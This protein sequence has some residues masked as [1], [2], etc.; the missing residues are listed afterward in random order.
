MWGISFFLVPVD[1][2]LSGPG[3]GPGSVPVDFFLSGPGL[4]P[5]PDSFFGGSGTFLSSY[6]GFIYIYKEERLSVCLFAMRSVSIIDS[7]TKL[8]MALP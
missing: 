7:V 3:L 4:G 5:G 1:F 8:F 2:F 6:R